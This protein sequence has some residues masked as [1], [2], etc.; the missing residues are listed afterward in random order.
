MQPGMH[1]SIHASINPSIYL[2]MRLFAHK[3]LSHTVFCL[4][5]FFFK[6]S[7]TMINEFPIADLKELMA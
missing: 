5:V 2:S 4:F 7:S 6:S 3:H 1:T